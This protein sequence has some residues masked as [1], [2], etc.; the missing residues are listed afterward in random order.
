MVYFI[1]VWVLHSKL[2]RTDVLME[3]GHSLLYLIVIIAAAKIGGELAELLGQP[4]VLGELLLGVILSL[5]ALRAAAHDP[6]IAFIAAIGVIL[7][8][9][10]TGLE[11]DLDE[12]FEVGLSASLV[13][14]IGVVVPFGFGFGIAYAIIGNFMH[15]MFLAATLT[16]TSVGITA[17][18]LSDLHQMG[19]KEAKIILGAAVID[20]ILGL[21]ILSIV[22]GIASTGSIQFASAGRA[23]AIAVAF[24]LIAV[25]AGIRFAPKMISLAQ[26]LKTRGRLVTLAFLFALVLA[27]VAEEFGLAEIIG[28]FAAGLVLA[29]TDDRVSIQRRIKPL[30]DLFIPV[31][32]VVVG[33][34]VSL[35]SLNPFGPQSS[36]FIIGLALLAVAI[37]GKLASGLGVITK[38]VSKLAVGVGMIPRGEVGLIFASVGLSAGILTE[39]LYASLIF[40]VFFTTLITPPWLKRIFSHR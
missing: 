27:L 16:A 18:V 8:L 19:S 31:F 29:T 26:K 34:Q 32:F 24:L 10:E 23:F 37:I 36:V 11:S 17:R 21:V 40:I 13:A 6:A 15:A 38:G 39:S 20:D 3:T 14:I 7:L 25:W 28:A 30:A 5:T 9:F 1:L 22:L 35:S 33:L 2:L 4:A 12:F